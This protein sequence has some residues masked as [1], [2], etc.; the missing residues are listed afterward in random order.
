MIGPKGDN[1]LE[2]DWTRSHQLGEQQN[3]RK[4][5]HF[6]VVVNV[7][8]TA[9]KKELVLKKQIRYWKNVLFDIYLLNLFVLN[10]EQEAFK[11]IIC[12]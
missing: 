12:L 5:E 9:D 8:L 7:K 3:G 4:E 11:I 2:P 6:T 10:V 1:S